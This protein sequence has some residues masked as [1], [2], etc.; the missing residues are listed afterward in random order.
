MAELLN[1]RFLGVFVVEVSIIPVWILTNEQPT[2]F[3]HDCSYSNGDP[4]TTK[5][6]LKIFARHHI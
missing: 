3:F 2:N 1:V 4:E 5:C 6:S